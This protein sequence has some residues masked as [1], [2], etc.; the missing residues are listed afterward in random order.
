M[1]TVTSVAKSTF[2]FLSDLR[3][4]N[5]REWFTANKDRYQSE[6]QKVI[7]LADQIIAEVS[8][9]DVL[10]PISGKKSLFRIYRD[11]RFSKNKAPYKAH[12]SGQMKRATALRRGGYYFHFEPGG[13]TIIAGG[14][15]A[16]SSPDL[17]RIRTEMA[18]AP[19]SFR[20]L[21]TAPEFVNT[22]GQ[23]KGDQVK[24]APKGFSKEDP[25]IDL[26]RYKQYLLVREFSDEAALADDF[27]AKAVDTFHHMLPFFDHM[28]SILTTDE[29]GVPLEGLY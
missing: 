26:L 10:E 21:I 24:T 22:F 13:K 4:N 6:H 16:P 5:N 14:F 1:S 18:A 20:T 12:F 11:V 7:Q 25:A 17:K 8:K 3:E 27:L 19:D 23:L 15:F 9:F 29:N 28:S 2:E